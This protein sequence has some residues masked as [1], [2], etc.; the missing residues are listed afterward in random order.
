MPM[1]ADLVDAAIGVDTHTDTHTA[2]VVDRLGAH[3]AT[4]QF[5]SHPTAAEVRAA[6]TLPARP[7]L[8]VSHRFL[9]AAL[10]QLACQIADLDTA[11]KTNLKNFLARTVRRWHR[12]TKILG[13]C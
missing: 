12:L 1:L 10:R 11:L 2:A 6:L 9:R 5:R 13:T 8:P 7:S 4:P 3:L